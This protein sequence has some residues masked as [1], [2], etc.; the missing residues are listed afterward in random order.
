MPEFKY[1]NNPNDKEAAFGILKTLLDSVK[2]HKLDDDQWKTF[3]D[4]ESLHQVFS[5]PC[6]DGKKGFIEALISMLV[7][8]SNANLY[9]LSEVNASQEPIIAK[10]LNTKL[11]EN[12]FKCDTSGTGVGAVAGDGDGGGGE[13]SG[14][15]MPLAEFEE[16]NQDLEKY[17]FSGVSGAGGSGLKID[18]TEDDIKIVSFTDSGVE[19]NNENNDDAKEQMGVG[20]IIKGLYKDGD[21]KVITDFDIIKPI[22]ASGGG[23]VNT[24][25]I[26]IV[27]A[28]VSLGEVF[29]AGAG[30]VTAAAPGGLGGSAQ[31]PGAGGLF[32]ANLST[33]Q[34]TGAGAGGLFGANLSTAQP[35]G[36]GAGGL[37]GTNLSTAP[38][39]LGGST[40]PSGGGRR[41][42]RSKRASK[43]RSKRSSKKRSKRGSKK[44][45]KRRRR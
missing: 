42:R 11:T 21:D 12:M 26:Y 7:G 30:G 19:V 43:K 5:K 9:N 2:D 22:L 8:Q 4:T 34:P 24:F 17:I 38:G 25:T 40:N 10:A 27:P 41:K 39:G 31:P 15:S 13:A 14:T 37:F 16:Q 36:A 28:A 35:T 45:S 20:R 44:R 23:S 18:K 29:G 1:F 3:L 32:G 33:A 6:N